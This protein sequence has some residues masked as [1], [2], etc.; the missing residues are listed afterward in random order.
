MFVGVVVVG[1]GDLVSVVRRQQDGGVKANARDVWRRGSQSL[2]KEIRIEGEDEVSLSNKAQIN[3][4]PQSPRDKSPELHKSGDLNVNNSMHTQLS[5]P[6][7]SLNPPTSIIPGTDCPKHQLGEI[8]FRPRARG[9]KRKARSGSEV[10]ASAQ[11]FSGK[12]RRGRLDGEAEDDEVDG[13]GNS[14]ETKESDVLPGMFLNL[15][16]TGA[17]PQPRRIL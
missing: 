7:R 6:T 8:E 11:S 10:V 1:G 13:Q 16:T 14:K 4:V 9:W 3:V 17:A 2:R 15:D 5:S 12:K